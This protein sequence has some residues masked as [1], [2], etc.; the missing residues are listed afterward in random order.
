MHEAAAECKEFLARTRRQQRYPTVLKPI[1][2]RPNF[3]A[4]G[5]GEGFLMAAAAAAALAWRNAWVRRGR[6]TYPGWELF[7]QPD[8][9]AGLEPAPAHD[10]SDSI[11]GGPESY[12]QP[13][14]IINHSG[15]RRIVRSPDVERRGPQAVPHFMW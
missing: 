8:S 4:V 5:G 9:I 10:V 13:S 14:V 15:G 3:G 1:P 2:S 11:Y 7:S 12:R 6:L